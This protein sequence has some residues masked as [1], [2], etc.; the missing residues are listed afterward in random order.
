MRITRT[1]RR[2][3]IDRKKV[4]YSLLIGASYI[5]YAYLLS[6]VFDYLTSDISST[7][8]EG[9]GDSDIDEGMDDFIHSLEQIDDQF[10]DYMD[11]PTTNEEKD[12]A[13]ATAVATSVAMVNHHPSIALL[14][15][16]PNSGTSFT[17]YI[18][19]T[20]SNMTVATNYGKEP[21]SRKPKQPIRTVYPGGPY[22]LTPQKQ[23]PS[24]FILTKT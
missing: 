13:V 19:H 15:S 24:T 21:A 16:Y 23:V 10:N 11:S 22:L 14:M 1:Q 7:K 5:F 4:A 9:D 2:Q 6:T 20:N 8:E 3:P 18:T 17:L 12:A